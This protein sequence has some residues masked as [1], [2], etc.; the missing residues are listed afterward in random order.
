MA[1]GSE[2]RRESISWRDDG[3]KNCLSH[4]HQISLLHLDVLVGFETGRVN[5]ELDW[6]LHTNNKQIFKKT[7]SKKVKYLCSSNPCSPLL[8]CALLYIKLRPLGPTNW[9]V[10]NSDFKPSKFERQNLSQWKSIHK[11]RLPLKDSFKMW[12]KLTNF[13]SLSTIFD[14]KV[15]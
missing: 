13:L 3:V 2:L 9:I 10:N 4:V 7:V 8:C 14:Q 12:L 1:H 15:D 11:F 6:P 5:F